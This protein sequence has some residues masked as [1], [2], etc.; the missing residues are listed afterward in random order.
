MKSY[1]SIQLRVS[2]N[3]WYA[4]WYTN[5][6]DG[7]VLNDEGRLFLA[8]SLGVVRDYAEKQAYTLSSSSSI[9]VYDIDALQRWLDGSDA[10][11]DCDV[12]L[13]AWNLFSDLAR[14][15]Q[16]AFLGDDDTALSVYEKLFLGTNPP[17]L[18]HG[19][20]DDEDIFVPIWSSEEQSLVRRVLGEGVALLHSAGHELFSK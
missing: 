6:V 12:V 13:S 16:K 1:F 15:L 18:R 4:L 10:V 2:G 14:S 19:L 11:I 8:S 5:D 9:P 3:D 20:N 7:L 17:A